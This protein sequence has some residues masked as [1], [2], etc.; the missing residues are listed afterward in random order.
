M[1]STKLSILLSLSLLCGGATTAQAQLDWG[2]LL[3]GAVK[4][5]QAVTI[6]DDQIAQY[7]HQS[8]VQMDSQNKVLPA[9]SPY[10][11]RLNRL[12]QGVDEAGGTP[13]N[14]KVYQTNQIR[15]GSGRGR[16]YKRSLWRKPE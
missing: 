12:T 5:T 11:I 13:L 9:N 3:S 6:S 1:K 14:F 8:V 16:R 10:T 7:V 4:A 2:R 15:Q